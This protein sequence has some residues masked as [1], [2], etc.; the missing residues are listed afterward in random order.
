M[1]CRRI[2]LWV[3]M[4]A[5]VLASMD[6]ANE[7]AGEWRMG[8]RPRQASTNLQTFSGSVGASAPPVRLAAE[9]FPSPLL[10]STE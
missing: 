1:A 8:L 6:I 7:L 2:Y 10:T 4:A 9:V 3:M 5:V